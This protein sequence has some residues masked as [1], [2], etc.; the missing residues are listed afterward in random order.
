[1]ELHWFT[2]HARLLVYQ[3]T[4]NESGIPEFDK[5]RIYC[6]VSFFVQSISI[7]KIILK[8]FSNFKKRF[9]CLVERS[10]SSLGSSY[11]NCFHLSDIICCDKYMTL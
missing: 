10:S 8:I 11:Q 2:S 9:D 6:F 5:D 7:L 4:K 3:Q 1:M